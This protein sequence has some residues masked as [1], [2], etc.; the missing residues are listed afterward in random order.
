MHA[1]EQLALFS[2]LA[3]TLA[4]GVPL[5]VSEQIVGAIGASRGSPAPDVQVAL[6]SASAL[7][8]EG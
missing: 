1:H 4:G 6:A 8:G 5:I 2:R 3:L 7:A